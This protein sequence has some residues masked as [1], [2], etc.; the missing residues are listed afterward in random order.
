M[1]KWVEYGASVR[2]A[3]Y[4]M[5]GAKA[6]SLMDGRYAV[7]FDDIRALAMPVLRHRI[8]TNFH[9]ESERVRSTDVISEL[10]DAVPAIDSVL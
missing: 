10:L 7:G 1:N 3:Q 6:R 8:L 2:A 9:A 5:L 4:L